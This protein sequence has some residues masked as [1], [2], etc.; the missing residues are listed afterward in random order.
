V[1]FA[2]I[3]WIVG[4]FFTSSLI[5]GRKIRHPKIGPIG[6]GKGIL[7]T[8]FLATIG[9]IILVTVGIVVPLLSK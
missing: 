7:I 3:L 6:F 4:G 2:V 1:K 9:F 8:C 5:Y